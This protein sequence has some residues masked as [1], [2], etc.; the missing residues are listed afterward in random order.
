MAGM[1]PT[2]ASETERYLRT[3]DSD[4]I[5]AAWPG[6]SLL[7]KAT[8]GDAE[9]RTALVRVV[10]RR[11]RR[12]VVPE[13]VATLDATALTLAKATPMVTGLF[14]ERERGPVLRLLSGAVVFLTPSNVGEILREA[15][16]LHTAWS[17]ANL[18]LLSCGAETLSA[19][20]PRIVG[21]SDGAR[22]YVSTGYFRTTERYSDFL[23]HEVAHVFHNWK[24][25]R[26]GLPETRRCEW[27]LPIDFRKR[28]TFAYACEEFS[29]ILEL[30]RSREER[31]RRFAELLVERSSLGRRDGGA[32]LEI[33][34]EAVAAR[35]GWKRI[36][37]QCAPIETVFGTRERAGSAATP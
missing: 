19:D 2:P 7:E 1:S 37:D 26:I 27:L 16:H 9:L 20:A 10:E 34:S 29:R 30:S 8:C 33:L 28:E 22:C 5:F 14:P 11:T 15:A 24:R 13:E 36:L 31:R 18:Y 32:C 12:A 21:L 3:G 17:L 4:P 6:A 35:N 23:V 25:S